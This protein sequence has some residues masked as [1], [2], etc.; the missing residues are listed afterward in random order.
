MPQ[1]GILHVQTDG[2]TRFQVRKHRS[3]Q[4]GLVVGEVTTIADEPRHPL[5][6]AYAPLAQTAR[7]DRDARRAAELSRRNATTTTRRGS[8][9]GSPSCCRCR[10]RSSRRMLEIN[11]ADVRL[12]VLQQ[13]LERQ[14]LI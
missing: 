1:L 10:C 9:I 6:E 3:S 4:S 11:D 8:A 14:G 13:F 5:P 12:T 2:E 7:A